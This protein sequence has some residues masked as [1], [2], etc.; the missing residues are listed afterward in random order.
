MGESLLT[1]ASVA[2]VTDPPAGD[3]T[4]AMDVEGDASRVV[5]YCAHRLDRLEHAARRFDATLGRLETIVRILKPRTW[6]WL[7]ALVRA[8]TWALAVLVAVA[9]GGWMGLL[10]VAGR[11][12]AGVGMY[13]WRK[14]QRSNPSHANN[15]GSR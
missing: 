8:V 10:P 11:L 9:A 1:P 7:E 4:D 14:V 15:S 5:P 3:E 2:P 12:G 6:P 13:Q